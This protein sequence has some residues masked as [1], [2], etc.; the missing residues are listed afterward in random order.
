M[1]CLSISNCCPD[2]LKDN[3]MHPR[4]TVNL[5]RLPIINTID[6]HF[7][8]C[9]IMK[10]SKLSEEDTRKFVHNLLSFSSLQSLVD[11]LNASM[12]NFK[13]LNKD[14]LILESKYSQVF[15]QS[16][17]SKSVKESVTINY[18]SNETNP[19]RNILISI[20]SGLILKKLSEWGYVLNK[21][22][23]INSTKSNQS[24]LQY[25]INKNM[26][27]SLSVSSMDLLQE[28]NR[29]VKFLIK[30]NKENCNS[31][32]LNENNAKL[33][34]SVFNIC[35][36][37]SENHN[38]FKLTFNKKESK[39]SFT[40]YNIEIGLVLRIFMSF[41]T[42]KSNILPIIQN[43][44]NTLSLVKELNFEFLDTNLTNNKYSMTFDTNKHGYGNKI[45][46][47]E[48]ILDIYDLTIHVHNM[49]LHIEKNKLKCEDFFMIR[50][51]M[52][53]DKI[54]S[55]GVVF[56]NDSNSKSINSKS[57]NTNSNKAISMYLYK[58]FISHQY[59][60]ESEL[61]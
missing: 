53:N 15:D 27:D 22:N 14:T 11:Y 18:D 2:V 30:E 48:S 46:L 1:G 23:T 24:L 6:C 25:N 19:D 45:S 42:L 39:A 41:V 3:A 16:L 35:K 4:K 13:T 37:I 9:N 50:I 44:Y 40:I 36:R 54:I 60:V 34:S 5:Q 38:C 55:A 12:H 49:R 43:N 47:L 20:L 58:C 21:F 61:K 8:Q 56:L 26:K 10:L 32:N 28:S 52:I 7:P 29:K 17:S 31:I 57:K 51:E 33:D 59:L